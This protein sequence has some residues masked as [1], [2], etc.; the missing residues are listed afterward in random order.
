[1]VSDYRIEI[2]D[3]IMQFEVTAGQVME[4]DAIGGFQVAM[5]SKIGLPR[6]QGADELHAGKAAQLIAKTVG[7]RRRSYCGSSAGRRAW[8]SP[9]SSGKP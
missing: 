3:L 6:G 2:S 7:E 9:R 4:A 8:R 5:G 1:M